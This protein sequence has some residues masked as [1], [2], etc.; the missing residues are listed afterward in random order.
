MTI[1][2]FFAIEM[3]QPKYQAV[4]HRGSSLGNDSAGEE[5]YLQ[6]RKEID[7]SEAIN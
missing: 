3:K 2:D 5:S 6:K 7:F 4:A 1:P